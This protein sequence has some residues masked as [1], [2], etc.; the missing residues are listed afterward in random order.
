MVPGEVLGVSWDIM[1]Q[2]YNYVI[3]CSPEAYLR[4]IREHLSWHTNLRVI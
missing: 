3:T 2:I 4:V 1:H